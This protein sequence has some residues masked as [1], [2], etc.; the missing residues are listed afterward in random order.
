MQ[1]QFIATCTHTPQQVLPS[2]LRAAQ[3]DPHPLARASALESVFIAL[4][5]LA[6]DRAP[7]AERRLA[8][9]TRHGGID[10]QRRLKHGLDWL[11]WMGVKEAGQAVLD[12]LALDGPA[13]DELLW[14]V[15]AI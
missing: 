5:R 9:Q 12:R 6:P 7:E 2:L 4:A 11:G 1:Y 13:G 14:P 8:C 10:V 3:C 15:E